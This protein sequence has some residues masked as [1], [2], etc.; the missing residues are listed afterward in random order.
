MSPNQESVQE[1]FNAIA[2]R[3]D[4]LNRFLSVGIDRLWRRNLKNELKRHFHGATETLSILDVASGTGDVALALCSLRPASITATDISENMM[5]IG[6]KKASR[7]GKNNIISFHKASAEN[8]PFSENHFD[9]ATVA[10]GV[11]NF[12]D[13]RKGL[14]EMLRVVKPGGAILILEFSQPAK[15]P[16]RQLYRFYSRTVIPFFGRLISHHPGAYSYLPQ[17][18]AVFPAGEKFLSI[19]REIGYRDCIQYPMTGGIATLYKG[20]K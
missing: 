9:A 12:E 14:S 8:L 18:A 13:L 16:V 2:G 3:Y 7:Q 17:T 11:R 10:F 1:M 6:K 5:E 20:I 19:L 15:A 4:F